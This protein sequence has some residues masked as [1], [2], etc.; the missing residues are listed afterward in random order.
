MES[1]PSVPSTPKRKRLTRDQRR[2]I[3][4]LR[5]LN[6]TYS[7]IASILSVTEFAVQY[8]CNLQKATPKK[9]GRGPKGK[10]SEQQIDELESFVRQSKDTRRMTYKELGQ[11]FDIGPDCVRR[12]LKKRGYSRRVALRKPP[13]SEANRIARLEWAH[14]HLHWSE[15]QW[16]K[17]LWTDETWVKAG[18]HRK[19]W[20][21]RKQGEEL[22]P[23]CIIK[24]IPKKKG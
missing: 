11:V 16:Y 9:T 4:L 2:D 21:T 19:T 22:D 20:I 10:L 13:I 1:L 23:T 5:K 24:R 6:K 3:L 14:E 15:E 17:I 12:A 18:R 8:T 7:E